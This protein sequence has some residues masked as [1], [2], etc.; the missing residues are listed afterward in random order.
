M[1]LLVSISRQFAPL[2][3]RL[4]TRDL[5]A[6]NP[7]HSIPLPERWA[8]DGGGSL[9]FWEKW[10]LQDPVIVLVVNTN[11]ISHVLASYCCKQQF[12]CFG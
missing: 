10:V 11:S 2:H 4:Q 3:Y 7:L 5:E 8:L 12:F 1:G 6:F 9:F